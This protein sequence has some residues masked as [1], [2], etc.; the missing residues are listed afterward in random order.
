M[1]LFVFIYP[2]SHFC[3]ASVIRP[4][5]NRQPGTLGCQFFLSPLAFIRMST[6]FVDYFSYN[7]SPTLLFCCFP[8]PGIIHMATNAFGCNLS[9]GCSTSTILPLWSTEL[10]EHAAGEWDTP[11]ARFHV[12]VCFP[13]LCT[14]GSNF[15]SNHLVSSESINF[16]L[17]LSKFFPYLCALFFFFFYIKENVLHSFSKRQPGL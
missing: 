10:P 4:W 15:C 13:F 17:C 1:L 12:A 9:S 14:Q 3:N 16:W 5:K 6:V 7:C 8:K 2:L 11:P